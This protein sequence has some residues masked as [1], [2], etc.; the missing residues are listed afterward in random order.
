MEF[1]YFYQP[2]SS[3]PYYF[4]F[5]SEISQFSVCVFFDFQNP[6]INFAIL[7]SRFSIKDSPSFIL[8]KTS[9]TTN[10]LNPFL[11]LNILTNSISFQ[12]AFYLSVDIIIGDF[13]NIKFICPNEFFISN[14]IM[15]FYNKLM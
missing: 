1:Y 14:K 4:E 5:H 7:Y 12:I 8:V 6:L 13:F 15:R 11:N 3:Y 9:F 2:E 10:L